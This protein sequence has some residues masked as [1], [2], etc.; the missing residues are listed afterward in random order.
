MSLRK[1]SVSPKSAFTFLAFIALATG[2]TLWSSNAL[3]APAVRWEQGSVKVALPQGQSRLFVLT[4]TAQDNIPSTTVR[5]VPALQPYVTVTPANI[6]PLQKGQ[7]VP[8]T[9]NISAPI[10][11]ALATI[12]GTVQLRQSG[13]SPNRT[14][15]QPLPVTVTVITKAADDLPPD[16]GEAGKATLA[17]IDSNNNGVRDDV[18][19]Y[20]ATIEPNSAKH[21]EA[22]KSFAVAIQ[23][24]LLQTNK[25]EAYEAARVTDRAMDCL[26]YVGKFD[27]NKWKEVEALMVNTKARFSAYQA[28]QAAMNDTVS[29]ETPRNQLSSTCTFIVDALPN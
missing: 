18:E 10:A 28:F 17:G 21:R 25:S 13:D 23:R 1:I 16:P 7:N 6:P 4:L 9:L 3:A 8:V 11:A 19:I 20:I 15:P 12:E 5:V 27:E 29:D 22:L 26:D 2:I 14:F 24:Q